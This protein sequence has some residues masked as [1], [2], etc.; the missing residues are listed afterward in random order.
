MKFTNVQSAINNK[1][2]NSVMNAVD[3]PFKTNLKLAFYRPLKID[4]L[5]LICTCLYR[6][7]LFLPC[8]NTISYENNE[9]KC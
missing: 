4:T 9:L 3:T 1:T 5:N 6:L 7:Y 2:M 8:C